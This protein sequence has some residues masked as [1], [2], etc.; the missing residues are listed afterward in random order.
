M[1]E[2][3]PSFEKCDKNRN[4]L[5]Q[6]FNIF[7]LLITNLQ[8]VHFAKPYSGIKEFVKEKIANIF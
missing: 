7:L 4:E 3:C 6:I 8:K 5:K 2:C 1:D